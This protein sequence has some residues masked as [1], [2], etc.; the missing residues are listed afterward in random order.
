MHKLDRTRYPSHL[1]EQRR[2]SAAQIKSLLALIDSDLPLESVGALLGSDIE[3]SH[4]HSLSYVSWV[5]EVAQ[6]APDASARAFAKSFLERP[7]DYSK[8]KAGISAIMLE[9]WLSRRGQALFKKFVETVVDGQDTFLAVFD[10]PISQTEFDRMK[11]Q[12]E[13]FVAEFTP[14]VLAGQ[15]NQDNMVSDLT[16]FEVKA[17]K[18]LT[19]DSL[20]GQ[21]SAEVRP[22]APD[23]GDDE[24]K[25]ENSLRP[26]SRQDYERVITEG[27]ISTAALPVVFGPDLRPVSTGSLGTAF[28]DQNG[29]VWERLRD[30]SGWIPRLD[31]KVEEGGGPPGLRRATK[32][33]WQSC[34]T[35][36]SY[37]HPAN[38]KSG[39][40]S[41]FGIDVAPTQ[42]C[43]VWDGRET[44]AESVQP[45]VNIVV[46]E[47]EDPESGLPQAPEPE[48][49]P[50]EVTEAGVTR[51]L[52][53]SW[54]VFEAPV[55]GGSSMTVI[56]AESAAWALNVPMEKVVETVR[57][58]SACY[59]ET[60]AWHRDLCVEHALA[61]WARDE[62]AEVENLD[63]C[64]Q[65]AA[66][67][68]DLLAERDSAVAATLT[69]A[70]DKEKE[71]KEPKV[72]KK[73]ANA[74]PVPPAPP[75]PPEPSDRM[76]DPEFY[77]DD[78]Q[79][80]YDVQ[81]LAGLSPKKA[82]QKTKQRFGVKEL[83]VTPTGEVRSPGV[84]DRPKPPPPPM[85]GGEP[86]APPAPIEQPDGAPDQAAAGAPPA[87]EGV[88]E[89]ASVVSAWAKRSGKSQD[90]AER[91]WQKAGDLASKNYPDLSPESDRWYQV[92]MGIYR[93]MVG[94]AAESRYAEPET[95]DDAFHRWVRHAD[96]DVQDFE[97][98]LADNH[99]KFLPHVVHW[100]P[101]DLHE[102]K[103]WPAGLT[104]EH[105]ERYAK[106]VRL[107][108]M[109]PHEIRVMARR[110]SE[111]T[112]SLSVSGLRAFTLGQR[113]TRRLLAMKTKPVKSWT[114][115]DWSWASRQINT[116]SKLRA[117]PGPLLK[118]GKPTEKLVLL[119]AWGH[120]PRVRSRVSEREV[121]VNQRVN[122]RCRSCHALVTESSLRYEGESWMH[123]CG[124]AL[125]V[126]V[127]D[128]EARRQVNRCVIDVTPGS[129][130]CL[131]G[132][133]APSFADLKAGKVE[134]ADDERAEV[135]RKKAVW[136]FSHHKGKASAAVWK[137]IVDGKTYFVTNTHRAYN[138][139]PTVKG[140][141][142]R[143]HAFIKS[144]A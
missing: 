122:W 79:T 4:G 40:C 51:S 144:T 52:C 58:L 99:P 137:S 53:G 123:S 47:D 116:V 128:E 115:D 23:P 27:G 37:D 87:K 135:M 113:S 107:M 140:A 104:A 110:V 49:L 102:S 48:P 20:P 143:Y 34:Q 26:E 73:P 93:R 78:L 69:E 96:G 61:E 50:Y 31:T 55:A 76:D 5:L 15:R 114:E 7:H 111:A 42:I 44:G 59:P 125:I 36:A 131:I 10:G 66:R 68:D 98:W 126:P 12:T 28:T 127:A 43:D 132:E 17:A 77:R 105:D 124:K 129:L 32:G 94:V 101:A 100:A 119:R 95:I 30:A 88:A 72:A 13:E 120:E 86:G 64:L 136:H 71:P 57:D 92:K 63:E 75:E 46:S 9:V 18:S 11:L 82:E 81:I 65:I 142:N 141:I 41:Q 60:A 91:L 90:E 1:T 138:V 39:Q 106:W 33:S 25:R 118:D 74:P 89:V 103:K 108:N 134:L 84:T 6:L 35:C 8:T 112:T 70:D 21:S 19:K 2:A 117:S 130:P 67:N 3:S 16:I 14:L 45:V 22:G 121:M 56:V 54:A 83:L 29:V 62:G 109:T 133:S 97:E 38:G 139:A 85:P 24:R 80:Y